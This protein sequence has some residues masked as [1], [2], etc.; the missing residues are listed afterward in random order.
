[1]FSR[2][3]NGKEISPDD[4]DYEMTLETK[5]IENNLK[6]CYYSITVKNALHEHTGEYKLVAKNKYGEMETAVRILN[7]LN[8]FH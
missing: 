3:H 1:L 2:Y 6:E 7:N 5:D 4:L 8:Y